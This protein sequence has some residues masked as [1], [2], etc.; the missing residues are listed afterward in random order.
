MNGLEFL[1][2]IFGILLVLIPVTGLTL[3]FTSRL[4]LKPLVETLARAMR[5]SGFTPS[6]EAR[7]EIQELSTRIEALTAEVERLREMQDFD[8]KLAG[9]AGGGAVVPG[10]DP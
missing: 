9:V 7:L 5:E 8:R 1:I 6:P 4:A 10:R 3:V 2:P